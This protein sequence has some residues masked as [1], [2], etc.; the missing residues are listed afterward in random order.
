[1][2]PK[3]HLF[4]SD[5]LRIGHEDE[6][7]VHRWRVKVQQVLNE[8][9]NEP[10]PPLSPQPEHLSTDESPDRQKKETKVGPQA[11]WQ[12]IKVT[13]ASVGLPAKSH[14]VP[15]SWRTDQWCCKAMSA[16]PPEHILWGSPSMTC[17]SCS[18]SACPL[19]VPVQATSSLQPAP[20]PAGA[21]H[22]AWQQDLPCGILTFSAVLE[23][24]RCMH[25][26]V[27]LSPARS[28][29]ALPTES[30]SGFLSCPTCLLTT[31][32]FHK[33]HSSHPST[34]TTAALLLPDH[35]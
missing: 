21:G 1:M 14:K 20:S 11:V 5:G 4:A 23:H 17:M 3:S 10:S 12:V 31:L 15:D 28:S 16:R 25:H 8:L 18:L 34:A 22:T 2:W 35:Q 26:D 24:H 7:E 19:P 33:H 27:F 13:L 30:Q 6:A 9:A 29:D 32:A